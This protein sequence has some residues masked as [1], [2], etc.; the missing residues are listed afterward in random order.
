VSIE[1][2]DGGRVELSLSSGPWSLAPVEWAVP[3]DWADRPLRV[4]VHDDDV[5]GAVFI[6]AVSWRG[7]R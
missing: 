3:D 4:V 2:D 7:P 5:E 6:D 1:R